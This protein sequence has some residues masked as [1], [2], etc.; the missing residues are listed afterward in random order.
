MGKTKITARNILSVPD[1][2]YL[3]DQ[4]LYLVVRREGKS[5]TFFFRYSINGVRRDLSLGA[6]ADK[7]LAVV[8]TE[9]AKLRGQVAQGIDPKEERDGQ[10]ASA[11]RPEDETFSEYALRVSP[12][13]HAARSYRN[14][15]AIYQYDHA[16][17]KYAI[18]I[19]G[20][21]PIGQITHEEILQCL[22]PIWGT[23]TSTAKKLRSI[24][25]FICNYARAEGILSTNPALWS[26]GLDIFLPPPARVHQTRHHTAPALDDLKTVVNDLRSHSSVTS[27]AA[28]YL[29]ALTACRR[30]EIVGLK[31]SEVDFEG[32][33][34]SIPPER[35]KDG[36]DIPFV[37]PLSAQ[38][39]SLL[40][41]R[42]TKSDYVFP[43]KVCK[44]HL[45][46][47]TVLIMLQKTIART[48][49]PTT[50]HGFRSTFRDWAAENG[51]DSTVAEKCLMHS[52]GSKVVQAY[53]RTD[54]LDARRPVM[55][56]WAD[57]IDPIAEPL[58]SE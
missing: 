37:I 58:A 41:N 12:I 39:L 51:V 50:L 15:I 4:S 6:A 40:R 49:V 26:G 11:K 18:P 56:L 5:R 35:R 47:K 55:Q 44:G 54:L 25:S 23:H 16:L 42:P 38:A 2:R 36:K 7:S 9:A 10:K 46:T 29:L 1:G 30:S 22:R 24:L 19:I 21:V 20:N 28:A 33:T 8:K 52:A 45:N 13:I 32:R 43:S 53:L 34:I 17:K 3:I 27:Y 14:P 48:G 31:W 57:A